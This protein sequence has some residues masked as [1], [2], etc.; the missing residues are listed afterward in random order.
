MNGPLS[1]LR[2]IDLTSVLMGPYCTQL[3]GDMG[4]D[5]IKIENE[6][7]DST[8]YLG[9]ARN[10]GMSG[11]FLHVGRNKRSLVFS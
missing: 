1:G 8:R 10:E 4:A 9:P 2:V 6:K 5:V 7:G 3:L 11:T